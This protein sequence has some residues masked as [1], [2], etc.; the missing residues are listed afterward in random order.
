MV[1]K[2]QVTG[3]ILA[4]GKGRR[5]D[6]QDKGLVLYQGKALVEHVID[7]IRPQ[8]ANIIINANRNQ[9]TYKDLG[10]PVISDEM[11]N[12]QGPLAGIASAMK[13]VKTDYIITLPCDGPLLPE[14][15]VT[16]M[17]TT[18][19]KS[20]PSSNGIAVAHDG[21]RMQPVHAL[22]PTKLINS[23]EEFLLSDD[24]KVDHWYAKH[25]IV[26]VDFSDQADAFLNINK[27]EQL[28]ET[29]SDA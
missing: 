23:L 12:F 10:Y 11:S 28:G 9:Q 7:R 5:L 21:I 15:L 17:L 22:I 16:K 6:G 26:L 19:N 20:C 8:V 29:P 27:K 18:F 24:R 2:Q 3:V 1:K 25:N 13:T 4:G 14:N